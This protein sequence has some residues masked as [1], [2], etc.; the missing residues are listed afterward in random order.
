MAGRYLILELD[1]GDDAD[2]LL[3]H[4]KELAPV[5][6]SP[7]AMFFKPKLFCQCPDKQ[8]QNAKA[9]R[10]GRKSGLYMC[11]ICNRPSIHHESGIM[12]RLQWVFGYNQ[13]KED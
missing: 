1:S 11:L 10:K 12:G 13:L 5:K 6:Y 2:L 4:L 8:R 7:L 9:W 3:E